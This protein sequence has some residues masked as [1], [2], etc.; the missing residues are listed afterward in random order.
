MTTTGG[1]I[2]SPEHAMLELTLMNAE[3]SSKSFDEVA[4][5]LLERGV[6]PEIVTRLVDLWEKTELVAGEIIAVGQI[7]VTKIVEFVRANP[8]IAAGMAVGAAF[9]AL[10]ASVPFLG[11]LLAPFVTPIAVVGGGAVGANLQRGHDSG[12]LVEGVVDLARK[13][14]ALLIEIFQ[15]VANYWKSKQ[16][17]ARP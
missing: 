5:Y 13:F 14:F 17:S 4:A 6:P 3:A 15:G 10:M 2:P 12:N 16:G 7:V 1:T 9:S 11:P 8:S